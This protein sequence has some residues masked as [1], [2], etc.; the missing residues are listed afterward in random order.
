MKIDLT[1]I[2]VAIIT[3]SPP[4]IMA[5][6]AWRESKKIHLSINSRMTELLKASKGESHAEGREEGRA[7]IKKEIKK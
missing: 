4:T 7:E 2:L 3:A 6:L 5:L 1:L